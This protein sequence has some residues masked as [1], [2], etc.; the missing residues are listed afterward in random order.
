MLPNDEYTRR[1]AQLRSDSVQ[2]KADSRSRVVLWNVLVELISGVIA[3][4]IVALLS[5]SI[6][7]AN[8]VVQVTSIILGVVAGFYNTMK[9]IFKL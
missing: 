9:Y 8:K 7:G 4:I 5:R 1:L 2:Q 3:G 6:F